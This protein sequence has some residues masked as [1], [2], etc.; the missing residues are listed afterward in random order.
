MRKS[1]VVI[2]VLTMICSLLTG[3]GQSGTKET[4]ND[5]Q[6]SDTEATTEESEA[7]ATTEDESKSITVAVNS[8]VTSLDTIGAEDSVSMVA[9]A[10]TNEGLFVQNINGEIQNGLCESYEISDD[11]LTWT[12]TIRDDANW[13]NGKPVTADDFIYAWRRNADPANASLFAYQ[14]EMSN[15]KNQAAVLTGEKPLE[16]LGITAL[17][18]KTIQ[19]NLEAPCT[20]LLDL[21]AFSPWSPL[22]QEFVEAEGDKF[23]TT[24]D[25]VLYC[26]PYVVSAWEAGGSNITL[27]KNENYWDA[28]NVDVDEIVL[29]LVEDVQTAVMS[30]ETGDLDYVALTGD[31]VNQHS[32]DED[33]SQV[34]GNFNYYMMF[35]TGKEVL[36]NQALRQ[37]IAYSVNR[38]ELCSNVLMDGSIPAYTMVMHSLISHNNVD[39]ADACDQFYFYNTEK[40]QELWEQAKKE[41][42]ITSFTFTLTYDQEKDFAADAAAFIQSSVEST[43]DGVTVNLESTPKQ[44]RIQKAKD[45]DFECEI[46]GWGP[47]YADP[48]AI[49]AMYESTHPSNYCRW[50][51]KDFDTLYHEA[52]S[53]LAGDAD[54]R[55]DALMQC[56]NIC[57]EYAGCVPLFQTGS[58]TLTRTGVEGVTQ[59]ITG[60]PC[61]YKFVTVE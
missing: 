37:A 29:Q 54:A 50:V 56:A 21:L 13:S 3:C 60:V 10:N 25:D 51:S 36:N 33:F 39:F 12:F 16:N 11:Q 31:M 34:Q 14:I 55:W 41:L 58:A 20:Y 5:S 45:G 61:F 7:A 47:D 52:N 24:K 38:E 59:H 6:K 4:A 32:Q 18:D 53:T 22:N 30:Y 35:N 8:A 43:L 1:I 26:G 15:I 48:T 2:V 49:L 9:V 40:A 27:T 19:V 28:A 46:W 17:D 23:G 42:G 44:N 57:T